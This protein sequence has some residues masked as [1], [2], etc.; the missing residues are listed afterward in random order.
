[1][2]MAR[3]A[4]DEI[5]FCRSEYKTDKPPFWAR[6]SPFRSVELWPQGD[7]ANGEEVR[8]R[9]GEGEERHERK[10]MKGGRSNEGGKGEN[11]IKA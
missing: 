2:E 4:A 5:S 7:N 10:R 1:M 6:V 8:L 9:M 3:L 11:R